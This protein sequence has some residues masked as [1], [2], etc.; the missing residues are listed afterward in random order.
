MIK[1]MRLINWKSYDDSIFYIDPLTILIGMNS[2]GKSNVIDALIFINR[3]A[4]GV[5][6][7]EAISGDASLSALRGGMDWVCKKNTNSFTIELLM[8]YEDMEYEY[9]ITVE[10]AAVKALVR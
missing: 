3:I 9:S 2:S 5:G 8:E 4:G 6:I 1:R 7:F 10:I